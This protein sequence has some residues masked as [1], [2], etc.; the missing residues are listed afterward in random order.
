MT[1]FDELFPSDRTT[2]EE[3]EALV[4]HLAAMRARKTVEALLPAPKRC[5]ACGL[6][7]AL[8][9]TEVILDPAVGMLGPWCARCTDGEIRRALQG[10]PT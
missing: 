7:S 5:T 2:P 4:W 9:M 1:T 6:P 10:D 8:P 3:R